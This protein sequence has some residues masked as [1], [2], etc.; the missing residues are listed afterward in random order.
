MA[1]L[2]SLQREIEVFIKEKAQA[3]SQ[4]EQNRKKEHQAAVLIQSWFRGCKVRTYLSHLLKKA[5]IIQRIWRSFRANA[6]FIQMVK[7]AYF[8][9]K[10]NFYKEM[11]VKIQKLWRGFYVRK[12]I[13]NFY[14]RKNYLNGVLITNELVRR[15]MD[16]LEEVHRRE[17]EN[18]QMME[19]ERERAN[20]AHR[21]HHLLST[22]QRPGIFNSPF[23][24]APDEMEQLLRQVKHHT[25]TSMAP[26]VWTPLLGLPGTPA[27]RSSRTPGSSLV[28]GRFSYSRPILPPIVS[29]EK[30]TRPQIN[31][32][33]QA[34][35]TA[36]EGDF[37]RLRG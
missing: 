25:P 31:Q 27:P 17:R 24:P 11:A 15:E 3:H 5:V 4:A 28:I 30:P 33:R 8:I 13:H 19:K 1:E 20:Q 21:S 6:H 18:F 23:R 26:R 7:A 35:S 22:K 2:L 36:V 14:T 34:K 29:R 32:W 10:M 9:T 16:K 37:K 12:Y